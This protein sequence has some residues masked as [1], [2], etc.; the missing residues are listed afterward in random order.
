MRAP[1]LVLRDPGCGRYGIGSADLRSQAT[2]AV[3]Q[4]LSSTR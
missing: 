2:L 3:T 4:E 1:R